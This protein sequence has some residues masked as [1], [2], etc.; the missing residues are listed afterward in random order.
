[1]TLAKKYGYLLII[2]LSISISYL[3]GEKGLNYGLVLVISVSPL[4]YLLTIRRFDLIDLKLLLMLVGMLVISLYYGS[5]RITSY[6]FSICLVSAFCYLKHC[7]NSGLYELP[8]IIKIVK[9]LIYAYALV[10]IV[11]Q[12]CVLLGVTPILS[13]MY[14]DSTPWKLS[15]LSPEPSHLVV[16]VLFLAYSYILLKETLLG[17]RY[18][19]DDFKRDKWIWIAYSWCML[20]CGS[21][22]GIIYFPLI[23]LRYIK[24]KNLLILSIPIIV[25]FL[26]ILNYSGESISLNRISS[27]LSAMATLDGITLLEADHSAAMRFSPMV[28]FFQNFNLSDIHF[29]IG[30]GADYAKVTLNLFMF[31]VSGD[32]TYNDIEGVNMGGFWGYI[33]DYG[34]IM[35][36]L[37]VSAIYSIMKKIGEPW[38]VAIYVVLM[39]FM[40]LNMQIFWFATLLAFII[41]YFKKQYP[42]MAKSQNL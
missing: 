28:Y 15:S 26:F 1:M 30:H 39:M 3:L 17:R 22:S 16:F 41:S 9:K 10:L 19:K 42:L 18:V 27:L 25:L 36:A 29:W 13:N 14:D 38:F 35:F 6:V 21:T 24:K 20:F 37:L 31:D 23:L 32:G 8:V 12:L 5:L 40:G 4:F 11:Q 34:I 33:M 2:I 7:F